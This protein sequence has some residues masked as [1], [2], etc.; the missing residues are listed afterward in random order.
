V[1]EHNL[2]DLPDPRVNFVGPFQSH[3]VIVSGHAVPFLTATPRRDDAVVLSLDRRF[4]IDLSWDEAQRFV[5]FLAD[6]IAV[7]L[8]YSCHPCEEAP[9]PPPRRAAARVQCLGADSG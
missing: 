6:A 2:P 5:P 8:G 7:A 3:D 1:E 4:R 9:E